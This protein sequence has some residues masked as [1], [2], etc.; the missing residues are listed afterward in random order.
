MYV[1]D[2]EDVYPPMQA[3]Y[4][5]IET[6]WRPFLFPYMG[7]TAKSYD[8]PTE[9]KD[10]YENGD[11]EVVGKPYTRGE[12]GVASGIGAVNVHWEKGGAQPPFGRPEGYENNLC[13]SS[14]VESAS[15]LILLGDGHSDWGGWPNDRWWIWKELGAANGPGF[16]RV[17]QNDPGAPRH[18]RRSNYAFGDASVQTWDPNNLPC[19]RQECWWSAALDPH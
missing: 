12:I 10:R 8:C 2:Q 19:N 1:D 5:G 6:S 7:Q 9:K 15:Q 13:K 3:A 17:L 16:N 18:N 4:Q 14:M 11:P